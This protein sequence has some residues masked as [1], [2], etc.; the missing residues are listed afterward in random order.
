MVQ[1]VVLK[2]RNHRGGYEFIRGSPCYNR[3]WWL[4]PLLLIIHAIW[5]FFTSMHLILNRDAARRGRALV[6]DWM[7][8]VIW[9][10]LPM[11][12][13]ILNSRRLNYDVVCYALPEWQPL[14]VC[15]ILASILG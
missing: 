11:A 15:G 7:S 5:T 1:T 14:Y 13:F 8:A 12:V 6:I 3:L 4:Y 2:V 9:T 10:V